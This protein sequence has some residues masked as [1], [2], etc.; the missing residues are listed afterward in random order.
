MKFLRESNSKSIYDDFFFRDTISGLE[1]IR[2]MFSSLSRLYKA[3]DDGKQFQ[4]SNIVFCNKTKP[5]FVGLR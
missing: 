3:T 2:L 5:S 1:N 4:C